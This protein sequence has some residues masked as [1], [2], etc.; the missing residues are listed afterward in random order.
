MENKNAKAYVPK[1]ADEI[2]LCNELYSKR[3]HDELKGIDRHEIIAKISEIIGACPENFNKAEEILDTIKY[4]I[5][6]YILHHEYCPET[7]SEVR[8]RFLLWLDGK[9]EPE[10]AAELSNFAE[11]YLK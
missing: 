10:K 3:C 1:L 6:K 11:K 7:K 4:D 8:P 2:S 9:A 5:A